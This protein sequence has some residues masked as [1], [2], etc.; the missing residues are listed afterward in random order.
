MKL[1]LL[2]TGASGKEA[3]LPRLQHLRYERS[4][5]FI[6]KIQNLLQKVRFP[7]KIVTESLNIVSHCGNLVD[8]IVDGTNGTNNAQLVPLVPRFVVVTG[9]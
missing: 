2:E 1:I 3:V 8:K 5:L 6:A 9:L 4:L 7:A